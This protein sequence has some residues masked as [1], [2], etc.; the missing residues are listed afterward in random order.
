MQAGTSSARASVLSHPTLSA[1][2]PPPSLQ[3]FELE[4]HTASATLIRRR[5]NSLA[6]L[7]H[8]DKSGLDDTG[9]AFTALQ[10]AAQRL[11]RQAGPGPA[12]SNGQGAAEPPSPARSSSSGSGNWWWDRWDEPL[13]R[14]RSGRAETPEEAAADLA[15]LEKL[16]VTA[17]SGEVA[18]RQ[19]A[20]FESQPQFPLPVLNL[21]LQRA[22]DALRKK[23]AAADAERVPSSDM[24]GFLQRA[25]DNPSAFAYGL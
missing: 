17:L 11:A 6:R 20:L 25:W 21:R 2:R 23:Q 14:T 18:R 10:E 24:G 15:A 9:P 19:A 7:V 13:P 8:P 16:D 12:P 22:K 5:F 4:S 3:I 1:Q